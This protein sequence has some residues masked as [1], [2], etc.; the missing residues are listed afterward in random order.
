MKYNYN[1]EGKKKNYEE[2]KLVK[3]EKDQILWKK[4]DDCGDND[5]KNKYIK[6]EDQEW[7]RKTY[8]FE[9]STLH[10]TIV[11]NLYS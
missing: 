9:Q 5:E 2:N 8:Q 10:F 3:W 4:N 6:F 1:Y 7:K 11:N